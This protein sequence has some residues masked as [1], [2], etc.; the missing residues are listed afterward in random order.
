MAQKIANISGDFDLEKVDDNEEDDTEEDE[1]EWSF[2]D[3]D[4]LEDLSDIAWNT[5]KETVQS[6]CLILVKAYET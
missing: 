2:D 3:F 5:L 1:D 6:V 4:T